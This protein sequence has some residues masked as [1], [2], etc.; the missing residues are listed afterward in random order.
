MTVIM[1]YRGVMLHLC[2]SRPF[3]VCYTLIL[4]YFTIRDI[5]SLLLFLLRVR[6]LCV[7]SLNSLLSSFLQFYLQDT[8]SSNG[9]FINSQ[10]LSRGSEES[11]PCEVLSGDIIQFGVDVTENTRKGQPCVHWLSVALR[12]RPFADSVLHVLLNR[13]TEHTHTEASSFSVNYS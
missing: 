9:T 3:L 5:C 12:E 6:F 7:L 11:P 1:C 4:K 13:V 2:C 8:K 10:R